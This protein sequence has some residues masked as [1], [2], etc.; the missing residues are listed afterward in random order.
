M[1]FR[2]LCLYACVG[3]TVIVVI[4]VAVASIVVLGAR[5]YR[6]CCCRYRYRYC[7]CFGRRFHNCYCFGLRQHYSRSQCYW[8]FH[9]LHRLKVLTSKRTLLEPSCCSP[10]LI[11]SMISTD[12]RRRQQDQPQRLVGLS[13]LSFKNHLQGIQR[14]LTS[15]DV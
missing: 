7:H 1:C 4:V 12:G 3:I 13:A 8:S 6:C 14:P 11:F 10:L 5:C 2:Y 15:T 9:H